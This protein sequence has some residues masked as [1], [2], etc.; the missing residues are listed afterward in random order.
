M[1]GFL[2]GALL[3]AVAVLGYLYYEEQQNDVSIELEAP[4]INTN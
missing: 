1:R 2:I 4:K 3:V